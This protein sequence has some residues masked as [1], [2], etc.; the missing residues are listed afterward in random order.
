MS[1]LVEKENVDSQ[2][3]ILVGIFGAVVAF[4]LILGIQVLYY[5]MQRTDE[6]KKVVA[7]GSTSLKQMLAEQHSSI[8]G[9]RWV[10]RDKDE[11]AI[12]IERAMELTVHSLQGAPTP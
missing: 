2:S 4:V 10:D 11:V 3:V 9:Y 6:Y 12:P 7:P 1:N 8:G 5:R